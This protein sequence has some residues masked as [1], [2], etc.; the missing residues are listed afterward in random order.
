MENI[1]KSNQEI[2]KKQW[3]QL[4]LHFDVLKLDCLFQETTAGLSWRE[5]TE[6]QKAL[7]ASLHDQRSKVFIKHMILSKV[8]F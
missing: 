5:E 3:S 7:L 6:I 4:L 8:Y 2:C 1:V